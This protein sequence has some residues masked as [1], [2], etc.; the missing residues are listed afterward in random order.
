MFI[1]FV[2]FMPR[3]FLYLQQLRNREFIVIRMRYEVVGISLPIITKANIKGINGLKLLYILLASVSLAFIVCFHGPNAFSPYGRK[4]LLIAILYSF[5][6]C[7][8]VMETGNNFVM[9]ANW[10]TDT[11]TTYVAY[12]C[13]FVVGTAG[14]TRCSKSIPAYC[15]IP[16]PITISQNNQNHCVTNTK[17]TSSQECYFWHQT[18]W[19]ISTH[20]VSELEFPWI[21]FFFLCFFLHI[22]RYIQLFCLSFYICK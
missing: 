11:R 7:R 16:P 5:F 21:Q 1:S 12:C 4:R 2:Q 9:A 19:P 22:F 18:N 13:V 8:H 17:P 10:Q 20:R 6:V 3:V 14:M 15:T